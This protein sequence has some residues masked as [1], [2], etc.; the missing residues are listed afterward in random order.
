MTTRQPDRFDHIEAML[1]CLVNSPDNH[2][3]TIE[4]QQSAMKRQ[5]STLDSRSDRAAMCGTREETQQLKRAVDY[6][7]SRDGE[8]GVRES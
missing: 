7:L 2:Q 8:T 5:Q 1:K 4:H 3:R 6:L